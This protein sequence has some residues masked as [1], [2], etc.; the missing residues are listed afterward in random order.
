MPS[1]AK[2]GNGPGKCNKP[3]PPIFFKIEFFKTTMK[4]KAFRM[5]T[6]PREPP[7]TTFG[8]V[9]TA[10]SILV[11]GR[12]TSKVEDS[13]AQ[14]RSALESR[15]R[16]AREREAREREARE[17][18]AREREA[19]AEEIKKYFTA[20]NTEL[21]K[22]KSKLIT[23]ELKL[24]EAKR[25]VEIH[26]N[27]QKALRDAKAKYDQATKVA[28]THASGSDAGIKLKAEV[29]RRKA[30]RLYKNAIDDY[31]L[32]TTMMVNVHR[33]FQLAR[34]E[35]VSPKRKE[36]GGACSSAKRERNEAQ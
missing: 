10:S 32:A 12:V 15:E 7:I 34:E 33:T 1:A 20:R 19:K 23:Y 25:V 5:L 26:N 24:N 17:R 8:L 16:E 30:Y 27:A 35:V 2:A 3:L 9:P 29:E 11:E 13:E 14:E 18:E 6:D 22:S 31:D 21:A 4:M 28:I 36:D